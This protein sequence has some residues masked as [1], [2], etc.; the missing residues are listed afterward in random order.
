MEARAVEDA[1]GVGLE[2][3][4]D[5]FYSTLSINDDYFTNIAKFRAYQILLGHFFKSFDE[6]FIID[7]TVVNGQTNYRHMSQNDKYNNLK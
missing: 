6:Y 5:T 3:I 1:E 4:A 2:E 7:N